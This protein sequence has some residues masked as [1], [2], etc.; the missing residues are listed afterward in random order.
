MIMGHEFS[1]FSQEIDLWTLSRIKNEE[2]YI[3]EKTLTSMMNK[4]KILCEIIS[5]L[6]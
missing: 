2:F 1:F 4:G 6:F 5:T 3:E